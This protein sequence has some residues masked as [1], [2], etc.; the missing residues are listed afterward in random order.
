MSFVM[1]YRYNKTPSVLLCYRHVVDTGT[2][3]QTS[4]HTEQAVTRIWKVSGLGFKVYFQHSCSAKTFHPI[5]PPPPPSHPQ[6]LLAFFG[7]LNTEF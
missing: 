3:V 5:T 7:S 2:G 6:T 4:L 1:V